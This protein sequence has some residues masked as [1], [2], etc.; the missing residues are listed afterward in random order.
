MKSK[1]QHFQRILSLDKK[2]NTPPIVVDFTL[3]TL[4]KT[5]A[6]SRISMRKSVGERLKT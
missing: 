1:T 4:K 3:L 2:I 6:D 5:D